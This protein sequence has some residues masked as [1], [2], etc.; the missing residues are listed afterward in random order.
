MGWYIP[1]LL[2]L[3][4]TNLSMLISWYDSH[5]NYCHLHIYVKWGRSQPMNVLI[6]NLEPMRRAIMVHPFTSRIS[7]FWVV[8]LS[9]QIM[10][11]RSTPKC[12]DKKVN[13]K[14]KQSKSKSK[15]QLWSQMVKANL[16]LRLALWKEACCILKDD[17]S[18]PRRKRVAS[19]KEAA[20]I[21]KGRALLHQRKNFASW[22]DRQGQRKRLVHWK[23]PSSKESKLHLMRTRPWGQ[24]P[25]QAVSLQQ[26]SLSC[27]NRALTNLLS[28]GRSKS[29]QKALSSYKIWVSSPFGGVH[30]TLV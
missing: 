18:P 17:A 26:L 25:Q 12:R 22:K 13:P 23:F 27:D 4:Y 1:A 5:K 2:S 20:C 7:Q 28:F 19:W 11:K 8:L 24:F 10:E 21:F 6:F 16:R 9:P 14:V 30:G 3:K 15:S 29:L